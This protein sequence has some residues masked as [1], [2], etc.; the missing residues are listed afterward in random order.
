MPSTSGMSAPVEYRA[1]T[2][3]LGGFIE[4]GRLLAEQL[5]GI[6]SRLDAARAAC[7]AVLGDRVPAARGAPRLR[8]LIDLAITTDGFVAAIRED[9][10]ATGMLARPW[11]AVLDRAILAG[12]LPPPDDELRSRVLEAVR[13]GLGPEEVGIDPA[14]FPAAVLQ[15]RSLTARIEEAEAARDEADGLPLIWWDGDH[16]AVDELD[17][18]LDELR[19]ERDALAGHGIEADGSIEPLDA[20]ALVAEATGGAAWEGERYGAAFADHHDRRMGDRG[21]LRLDRP[22]LHEPGGFEPQLEHIADRVAVDGRVALAFY[23][24]IGVERAA[25]LVTFAVG[26]DRETSTVAGLGQGLA[27]A[28]RSTSP[29]GAPL[30]DFGGGELLR[31][32][33]P[34]T[35]SGVAAYSPSLLFVDGDVGDRFLIEATVAA[36]ELAD[37][38][39]HRGLHAHHGYE[40]I[41]SVPTVVVSL[42]G[43]E[44]PRNIL[45]ARS[46]ER[47]AVTRAVVE[48]LAARHADLEPL[49]KPGAPFEPATFW[50][51]GLGW[52]DLR[53]AIDNVEG[54]GRFGLSPVAYPELEVS[55]PVTAFLHTAAADP[56]VARL[57]LAATA[58]LAGDGAVFDDPGTAAGVDL[59]LARHLVLVL[60]DA[61]LAAV[62]LPASV[63]N[64]GAAEAIGPEQWRAAYREVLLAGRG[65]A[66]ASRADRMLE[67]AVEGAVD[68]G[69][70][71]DAE[72][73]RPFAHLAARTEAETTEAL[74]THAASLDDRAREANRRVGTAVGMAVGSAG[75]IPGIAGTWLAGGAWS[76][77]F[78]GYP[79]DQ[80]LREVEERWVEAYYGRDPSRWERVVAVESLARRAGRD[81]TGRVE[82]ALP[83]GRTEVSYRVLSAESVEWADPDDGVWRSLPLPGQEGFEAMFPAYDPS[84]HAQVIAAVEEVDRDLYDARR[85][86]GQRLGRGSEAGGGPGGPTNAGG[87]GGPGDPSWTDRW[88]GGR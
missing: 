42:D 83:G 28:S 43:G 88:L 41:A 21:L 19:A 3:D 58:R 63:L 30:L 10:L 85:L 53:H 38:G 23:N 14:Y 48:E 51:R 4:R 57:V 40:D 61:D 78:S 26:D 32:P 47:P 9:L 81:G 24:R 62:G 7:L 59:V 1:D 79:T 17:G 66:L 8:A 49:L 16:E 33:L 75:W 31:Q 18:V 44:E 35:G 77:V 54:P 13:E 29:T 34:Q 73:V 72:L 36:L 22:E 45:L 20:V 5:T 11:P 70:R 74:L 15:H 56:E 6:V 87:G 52:S 37:D 82:V 50:A 25:N 27:L 68:D 64:D 76:Y 69:G 2:G 12:H 39:D 60:D 67:Q 55:S 46:A 80:E 65:Q 71:F 86:I 84:F